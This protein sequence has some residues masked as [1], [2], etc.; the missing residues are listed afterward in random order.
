MY[1]AKIEIGGYKKGEEVP[2]EQALVWMNMYKVSPVEEASSA[3][4]IKQSPVVVEEKKGNPMLDD[5]L[6]RGENVVVKNI[7]EDKLSLEELEQ[8]KELESKDKKRMKV[9]SAL[10]KKIKALEE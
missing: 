10:S 9:L 1:I 4:V 8:M 2:A 5:Y 6:A 7:R 3:P